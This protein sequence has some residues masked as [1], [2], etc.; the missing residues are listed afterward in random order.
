MKKDGGLKK[1]IRINTSFF[2]LVVKYVLSPD[3]VPNN[4]WAPRI[5]A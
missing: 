3:T 4:G 2:V 5:Y 1:F